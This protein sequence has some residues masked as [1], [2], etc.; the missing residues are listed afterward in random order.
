MDNFDEKLRVMAKKSN[1]KEPNELR[2]NI[3]ITCEKLE[4]KRFNYKK[5]ASVAAIFVAAVIAIGFYTPT[6]A[7]EVPLVKKVIRY[8]KGKY[9]SVNK[10][11]EE[12]L[13]SEDITVKSNG[14][15]ISIEEIYYDRVEMTIFY[16]IISEQPLNKEAKYTLDAEFNGDIE[17][18]IQYGS[19]EGEFIDEN[20][21]AGMA[22][23]YLMEKN[24]GE[25]PQI[26]NG[27][28]NIKG[29]LLNIKN[30]CEG[31]DLEVKP[32]ELSLDS[33]DIKRED[34]DINTVVEKDGESTKY[35]KA[36]K[37]PTGIDL[38][39]MRNVG[40]Y[41]GYL[42]DEGL[43]DSKKG[44]LKARGRVY[45]DTEEGPVVTFKYELPSENGELMIVPYIYSAG[46]SGDG[47]SELREV[48][49]KENSILDLD[50]IGTMEIEKIEY[51]KDETI[52]T[53]ETKGSLSSNTFVLSQLYSSDIKWHQPI[54]VR[55]IEVYGFMEMKADYV[56]KP[57]DSSMKYTLHYVEYKRHEIFEDEIIK[58]K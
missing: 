4:S 31:I 33:N 13:K 1:I 41:E 19:D 18:H 2:K 14:Y 21:Y 36:T 56:F 52:I 54:S 40:N 50:K 8:F 7:E 26:F 11:H 44:F 20:T 43:W 23:Y 49:F 47:S 22:Q 3:D 48:E 9:D 32:I 15:S 58:I 34:I 57:M 5:Y 6:Y 55:N 51:G 37:T 12:N 29:L 46:P 24:S 17:V 38:E 27:Y 39:V 35:I 16:K 53:V 45:K 25:L 30:M 10:G 42:L 28:L